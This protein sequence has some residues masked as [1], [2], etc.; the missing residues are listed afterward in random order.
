[1]VLIFEI[2]KDFVHERLYKLST[3]ENVRFVCSDFTQHSSRQTTVQA[4]QTP[5]SL[6][7]SALKNTVCES[8]IT[9]SVNCVFSLCDQ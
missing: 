3:F 8:T 2:H 6:T 4:H 1:M 7:A 9:F 5:P